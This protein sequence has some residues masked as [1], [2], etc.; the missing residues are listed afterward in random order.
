MPLRR[1][2]GAALVALALALFS[3]L[4]PASA[5]PLSPLQPA[6]TE[7]PDELGAHKSFQPHRPKGC[8]GEVCLK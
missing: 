6:L 4:Q 8:R 7:L 5:E 3:P 1:L 2:A